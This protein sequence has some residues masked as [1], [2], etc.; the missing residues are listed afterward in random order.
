MY[1]AGAYKKGMETQSTPSPARTH[2]CDGRAACAAAGLLLQGF[3]IWVTEQT[4][5]GYANCIR[6]PIFA[7]MLGAST[8]D[9]AHTGEVLAVKPLA[10]RVACCWLRPS[11]SQRAIIAP[12]VHTTR[13][14]A[15]LERGR[16]VEVQE[17]VGAGVTR[18]AC[19]ATCLALA[20]W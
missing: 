16:W 9:P 18:C 10:C 1:G 19:S 3:A 2:T 12:Q 11:T 6:D 5:Q 20:V 14:A 15:R 8:K 17:N 7:Q 13:R 4:R